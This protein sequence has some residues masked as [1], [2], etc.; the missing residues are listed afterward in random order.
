MSENNNSNQIRAGSRTYFFDVGK[1]N[2]G[3][4][5]LRITESRFKGEG[6]ERERNSII[7][8]ADDAQ[9]FAQTVDEMVKKL[10]Q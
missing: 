6:E 4:P 1:T 10:V 7:V 3:K 9:K 8:F 2:N 5:Y